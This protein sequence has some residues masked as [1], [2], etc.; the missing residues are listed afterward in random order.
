MCKVHKVPY[1]ARV[2]I[3]SM[4]RADPTCNFCANSLRGTLRFEL[5]HSSPNLF[6]QTISLEDHQTCSHTLWFSALLCLSLILSS[7][8]SP[9]QL[10]HTSHPHSFIS[11]IFYVYRHSSCFWP[12]S[13][14]LSMHSWSSLL[15]SMLAMAASS[16]AGTSTVNHNLIQERGISLLT[17]DIVGDVNLIHPGIDIDLDIG[18]GILAPSI[19]GARGCE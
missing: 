6:Q 14:Q 7:D 5:V 9:G 1:L 17:T 15:L 11:V 19:C 16:R 2:V 4:L 12:I 8:L 13:V 18:V 3:R 10:L